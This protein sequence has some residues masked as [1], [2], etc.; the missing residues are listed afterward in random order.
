MHINQDSKVYLIYDQ[1]FPG[2]AAVKVLHGNEIDSHIQSS[3]IDRCIITSWGHHL[4]YQFFYPMAI[5]IV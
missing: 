1:Y 4:V 3:P 5:Y 2:I